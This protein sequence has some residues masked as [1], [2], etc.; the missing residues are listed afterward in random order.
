MAPRLDQRCLGFCWNADSEMRLVQRELRTAFLASSQVV[1]ML[2][3]YGAHLEWFP[4]HQEDAPLVHVDFLSTGSGEGHGSPLQYSCLGNRM[5]RGAW[6]AG[7]QGVARVRNDLV[8]KPPPPTGVWSWAGLNRVCS[9]CWSLCVLLPLLTALVSMLLPSR[10]ASK[11]ARSRLRWCC[12]IA[13]SSTVRT[14]ATDPSRRMSWIK[15]A[16]LQMF[17]I[18]TCEDVGRAKWEGCVQSALS[19]SLVVFGSLTF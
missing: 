14:R 2:L 15:P 19:F 9:L 1:R 16:P 6:Q 5:D 10:I 4:G 3:A 18:S 8:T 13:C 12:W 17:G 11:P 7:V